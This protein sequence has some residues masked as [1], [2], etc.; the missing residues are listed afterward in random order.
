MTAREFL[1]AIKKSWSKIK[2]K[3]LV[4]SEIEYDRTNFVG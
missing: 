1:R 3:C 2:L 4:P